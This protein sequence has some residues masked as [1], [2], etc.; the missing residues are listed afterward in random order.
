[1]RAYVRPNTIHQTIYTSHC[2]LRFTCCYYWTWRI[3]SGQL[4]LIKV[5]KFSFSMQNEKR[6]LRVQENM[7]SHHTGIRLKEMRI[8]VGKMKTISCLQTEIKS[9]TSRICSFY[10]SNRFYGQT[11]IFKHKNYV[12]CLCLLQESSSVHTYVLFSLSCN[13]ARTPRN[14]LFLYL[15]PLL[16][17]HSYFLHLIGL[18]LMSEIT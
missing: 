18:E 11:T 9:L 13:H 14:H 15:K 1:M 6:P 8:N 2:A 10:S 12:F 3:C 17:P 4:A 5:T 7:K 16:Q